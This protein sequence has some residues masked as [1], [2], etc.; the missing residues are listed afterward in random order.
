MWSVQRFGSTL[1]LRGVSV[2]WNG[3][4][5]AIPCGAAWLIRECAVA[6]AHG[7]WIGCAA[8]G[9]ACGAGCG[10]A[11]LLAACIAGMVDIAVSSSRNQLLMHLYHQVLHLLLQ[12]FVRLRLL[13]CPG[14]ELAPE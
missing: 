12:P 1:Y 4:V 11:W 13:H 3:A 14:V 8:L 6:A 7:S 9:A 10:A 2:S 5:G